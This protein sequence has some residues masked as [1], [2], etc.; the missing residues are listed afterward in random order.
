[1]FLAGIKNLTPTMNNINNKFSVKY[2]LNL[3]MTD[4]QGRKY[5]KQNEILLYRI[6]KKK[7]EN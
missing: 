2:F 6:P 5:F 7:S 3:I 4:D 1:M